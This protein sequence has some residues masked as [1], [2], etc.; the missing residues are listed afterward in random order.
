MFQIQ[1]KEN[2]YK[3]NQ[4]AKYRNSVKEKNNGINHMGNSKYTSDKNLKMNINDVDLNNINNKL[5]F[6]S[7][8]I[9]GFVP[10]EEI[11]PISMNNYYQMEE[12]EIKPL[13]S[14]DILNCKNPFGIRDVTYKK[15]NTFKE[16][17]DSLFYK[18]DTDFA[19]RNSAKIVINRDEKPIG[20]NKINYN[21]LFGQDGEL[22]FEGDPFGGAKQFETKKDKINNIS[23]S[24]KIKKKPIYDARKAIEEAKIKENKKLGEKEEKHDKFRQFLKEIKKINCN[25]NKISNSENTNKKEENVKIMKRYSENINFECGEKINGINIIEPKI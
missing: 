12:R 6:S 22:K 21:E 15:S 5:F 7:K 10:K 20:G 13:K 8:K 1:D 3:Q 4:K 18:T 11:Q 2:I 9:N 24:S 19:K 23:K 17:D 14:K 16:I 25:N